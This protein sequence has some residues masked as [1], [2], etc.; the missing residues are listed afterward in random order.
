M[1]NIDTVYQT[2]RSLLRKNQQGYITPGEFNRYANMANNSRFNE[3]YGRLEVNS[4]VRTKYA[5]TQQ[6]EEKLAPFLVDDVLTIDSNGKVNRPGSLLRVVSLIRA[7]GEEVFPIRRVTLDKE[8]FWANSKIM[9]PTEQYA[10][11][12]DHGLYFQFW[13]KNLGSNPI[14][15]LRQPLDVSWA[16]TVVDGA[17]TYDIGSSIDFKW[18]PNEIGNIVSKI[19]EYAGMS[20]ADQAAVGFG[21]QSEVKGQ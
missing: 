19:L 17:P 14:T 2:V 12:T 5:E 13:P 21:A 15:Y 3:I 11:Y 8:A 10:M 18:E 9:P 1:I 4:P 20:V 16:Y 6:I 7:V